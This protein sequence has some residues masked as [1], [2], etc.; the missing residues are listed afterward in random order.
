M[1]TPIRRLFVLVLLLFGSL[2]FAS[3]WWSVFGAE[4]LNDNPANRRILFEEQRIKRGIIRAADGA[5]LAA[6][7]ALSQERY[8]RRY[9][10]GDLFAQASNVGRVD[11]AGRR[12]PIPPIDHGAGLELRPEPGLALH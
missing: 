12:R 11:L 6:N 7:R 1:N 10:T 8:A 4:G 5:V 9:P 2:V 3:S